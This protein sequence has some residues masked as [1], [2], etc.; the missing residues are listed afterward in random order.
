MTEGAHGSGYRS[1]WVTWFWLLVITVL[2]VAIVLLK[3]PKAVLAVSLLTLALMKAA[4]I[5]AY[6]MHLKYERLSL[7][8]TVVVP[9]VA[10]AVILFGFVAP[11]ALSVRHLRAR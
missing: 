4:L 9:M 11:D 6:F 2:E 8:Y 5:M 1:Y 7:I 10:L 3:V